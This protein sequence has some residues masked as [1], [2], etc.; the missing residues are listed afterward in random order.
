VDAHVSPQLLE[1]NSLNSL[2]CITVAY[3]EAWL[4]I[5]EIS[6]CKHARGKANSFFVLLFMQFKVI[7]MIYE[8][9]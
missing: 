8:K 3:G 5:L 6:G 9:E 7:D 1:R 2:E 4:V